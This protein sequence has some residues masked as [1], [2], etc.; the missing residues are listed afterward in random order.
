[1]EVKIQETTEAEELMNVR[2]MAK[3]LKVPDNTAYKMLLARTIDSFK[4]GKLR[5]VRK[6]DL[7]AYIESNRVTAIKA[8]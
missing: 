2:E 7:M 6:S 4:L 5:R 1:M 3:F 8:R